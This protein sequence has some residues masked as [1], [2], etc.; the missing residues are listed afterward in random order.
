MIKDSF[1]Y[2]EKATATRI[3]KDEVMPNIIWVPPVLVLDQELCVASDLHNKYHRLSTSHVDS[4]ML[5][6]KQEFRI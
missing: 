4:Q 1:L 3:E 2:V 5:G 6:S